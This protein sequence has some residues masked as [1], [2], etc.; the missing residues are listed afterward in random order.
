GTGTAAHIGGATVGGKTGTAQN[1]EDNDDDH[2]WFIGFAES[3]G[4]QVAV[5]VFLEKAGKGGSAKATQIAG[6]IMRTPLGMAK[7]GGGHAEAGGGSE[8]Q[9]PARR[10]HRQRG[11]ARRVQGREH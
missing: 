10:A 5:A 6:E 2:G 4:K 3:G 8:Q 1:G 11:H 7:G 9:I